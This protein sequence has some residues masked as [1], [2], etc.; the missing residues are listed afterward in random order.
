MPEPAYQ[1]RIDTLIER[2]F[3]VLP[4]RSLAEIAEAL[5]ISVGYVGCL[6]TILRKNCVYYGWTVPQAQVGINGNW[7]YRFHAVLVDR[8]GNWEIDEDTHEH[9]RLG[10]VST[11]SH[12][13]TRQKNECAAFEA[14]KQHTRSRNLRNEYDDLIANFGYLSRKMNRVLNQLRNGTEG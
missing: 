2:T 6:L 12:V 3:D 8:D 13:I 5:N 10:A 9:A 7:D 4:A 1:G 14:L 11:V